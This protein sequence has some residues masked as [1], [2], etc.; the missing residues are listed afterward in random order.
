MRAKKAHVIG[1]ANRLTPKVEALKVAT[2]LA[3]KIIEFPPLA[4]RADREA[5]WDAFNADEATMLIKEE[6]GA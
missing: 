1:L 2:N 3:R 6:D 5:V 4:L